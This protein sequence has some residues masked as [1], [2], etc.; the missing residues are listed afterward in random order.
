[1]NTN[2]IALATELPDHD[3]LARIAALAAKE[4]G[5]T[6]ELLAHLAALDSRPSLYASEGLRLA[7]H[8]L[9]ARPASLGGRRLQSHP[10]GSSVPALPGDPRAAGHRRA[11]R[12][13]GSSA[14][15][16][17]HAREPRGRARGRKSAGA[18]ARSRPWSRS[19]RRDPMCR[20]RC[21][22]CR[23]LRW[24]RFG[25]RVRSRS[26]RQW[27]SSPEPA[28]NA[29][30]LLPPP[31]PRRPVIETTS[32]ERYRVQF[33]VGKETH[34][35]LRRLQELL[36]REIPDGDPG[37]I[38]DRAVTLLLEKV[39]S[40]KMGATARPRSSRSIRP[41][42]DRSSGGEGES[43]DIPGIREARGIEARRWSVRFRRSGR[44]P[45]PGA[46]VPGVPPHHPVC[47]GRA[48][49]RRQHLAT[50]SPAQSIRGG[51]RLRGSRP[52]GER[53]HGGDAC[54]R[55]P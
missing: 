8:L 34:D 29:A 10:R 48:R 7:L 3:L 6:V 43:R 41:G 23:H 53:R 12:D 14:A 5:A 46:D 9:H 55:D 51:A 45:V 16:A 50:L 37:A 17:P 44:T 19:W 28:S 21:E 4:R 33:T 38:F 54:S 11:V 36:R 20:L 18:G 27:P 24:P 2:L 1:M 52:A 25:H 35:K 39:E 42:T 22:G 26:R 31:P 13:H 32:P 30:P 15:R 49:D 40:K 47:P